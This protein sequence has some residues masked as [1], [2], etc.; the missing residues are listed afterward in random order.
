MELI[1]VYF[2]LINLFI[3]NY[4]INKLPLFSIISKDNS[5]L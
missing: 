5:H 2:S 1:L 4:D 3:I